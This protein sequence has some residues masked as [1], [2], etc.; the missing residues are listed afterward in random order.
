M[1]LVFLGPPGAGK[2][3]QSKRL[4]EYLRIPHLSTGEMLRQAITNR[5]SDGLVAEHFMTQGQLVPDEI[6]M[7][8]IRAR[9]QEKDCARGCLFDGF[10]RT[11][12]QA[13]ALDQLMVEGGTPLEVVVELKVDESELMRR[14]INRAAVERRADDT[15][16]TIA[17]R[18]DVYHKQT[19]PLIAYYRTQG[20]LVS[21]DAMRPADDVFADIKQA[22]DSCCTGH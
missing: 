17:K 6:V 8:I 10:P 2:G 20:K 4:L 7:R 1:R 14:M 13:L 9:L 18:M 21:V 16:E 22:V 12:N 15:P 5:Q 19:S 3:T 11:L